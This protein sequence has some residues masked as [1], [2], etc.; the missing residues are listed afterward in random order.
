M[1]DCEVSQSRQ[2]WDGCF[3]RLVQPARLS[4]SEV[5]ALVATLNGIDYPLELER[6]AI[7]NLICAL[8]RVLRYSP[9]IDLSPICQLTVTLT[10]KHQVPP[11]P[12][13]GGPWPINRRHTRD[14]R[15]RWAT[16]TE[17]G[18]ARRW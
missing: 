10:T 14:V 11:P 1:A 17:D 4:V 2:E 18:R 6:S 16:S 8:C 7:G 13:R 3:A 9:D 15:F 5:E 12:R